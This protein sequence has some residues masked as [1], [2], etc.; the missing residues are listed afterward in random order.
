M[1][2]KCDGMFLL[3]RLHMNT[4]VHCHRLKDIKTTLGNISKDIDNTYDETMQRI[5]AQAKEDAELAHRI[6]SWIV[7]AHRPLSAEELQHALATDTFSEEF[8]EDAIIEGE[9]FLPVCAGLIYID[10]QTEKIR[11][12]H[13][14]T[15]EYFARN[16]EKY[17]P[18]ADKIISETC[19]AY[20]S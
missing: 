9:I 15:Q 20:L 17:F 10:D 19:L 6:L 7:C 8:D 3:A 14:T 1:I 5:D 12:V 16:R 13:F 2:E 11:L 4:L 18:D